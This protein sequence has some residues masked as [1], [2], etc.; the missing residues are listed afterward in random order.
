VEDM[1]EGPRELRRTPIYAEHR[2]AGARLVEF[3]GWEMPVQYRSISEEH[4]AVRSGAGLFDVS[5]MGQLYIDGPATSDFLQQLLPLDVSRLSAGRMAYTVMCNDA[6]GVIDDL[7]VYRHGRTAFLLVVNAARLTA[8]AEWLGARA[9]SWDGVEMTDATMDKGM[10]AIQGPAAENITAA[11]LGETVR[12]LGFFRFRTTELEG[13]DV[14]VSRSGY[15]GEDGF[16]VICSR[17]SSLEIWRRAHAL[18]AQP[19]GLGARDTLRTE[20]GYCLYGHELSEDITPLEAGLD[21]VLA[22]EKKQLFPGRDRLRS[23]RSAGGY[24]LLRGIKLLEKGIPR[25]GYSVQ[26]RDGRPIGTV[27]SGTYS[28]TLQCGIALAFMDPDCCRAGEKVQVDLR[29]RLRAAE[30]CELPLVPSNIKRRKRAVGRPDA[31]IRVAQIR[32]AQMKVVK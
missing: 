16:E 28:P 25:P 20:M 2:A 6:G 8:D 26:D 30:V 22:L 24:R 29:G 13:E 14:L 7:A 5:H 31:Q 19:A 27:S 15:T 23:L 18:G 9:A 1:T 21:W 10:L 17:G 11:I 32:V 4:L 3:A 12:D